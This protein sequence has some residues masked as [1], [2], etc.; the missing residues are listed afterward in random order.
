MIR[1]LEPQRPTPKELEI[2]RAL[3]AHGPG[4]VRV[5]QE[6][7]GSERPRGYTT[8]LK[9]MQIM[10]GK[11]LLR[12]DA[13]ARAHVYAA[14]VSEDATQGQ[15]VRDLADR[16]FG[17]SAC[18]LALHALCARTPSRLELQRLRARIDEIEAAA[19]RAAPLVRGGA[20]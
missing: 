5:V 8:V 2:L 18:R 15:L 9:L 11:G 13:S 19:A 14:A 4:T 20:G 3:W 6:R 10:A 1:T 16:A 17:G 7:L 12:R